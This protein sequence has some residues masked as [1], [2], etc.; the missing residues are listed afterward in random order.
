MMQYTWDENK[1][2]KIVAALQ[3]PPPNG[4]FE[5]DGADEDDRPLSREEMLAGIIT[6]ENTQSPV[7][8]QLDNEILVYFRS[9][10]K[11]WQQH[12][13]DALKQWI[14]EHVAV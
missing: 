12:L 3:T 2:Q 6:P 8:L 1:R 14:Q 7:L 9:T 13:N 10:G 11:E 5:W 4:Y